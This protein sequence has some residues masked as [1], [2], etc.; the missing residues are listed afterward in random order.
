MVVAGGLWVKVCRKVPLFRL[1]FFAQL[2]GIGHSAL[3]AEQLLV[4]D[5][6]A[7]EIRWGGRKLTGQHRGT[8]KVLS[9]SV[10]LINGVPFSGSLDVDMQS[11][12]NTDILSDNWRAKLE[13]HLKSSDF[14]AVEDFPKARLTLVRCTSSRQISSQIQCD[15]RLHLKGRE[16]PVT[17][18][19]SKKKSEIL[20]SFT[21]DRTK[22]GVNYR[23]P[24]IAN[25]ILNQI[26][27]DEVQVDASIRFVEE[28]SQRSIAD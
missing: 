21:F 23:S 24:K 7:S 9:G 3:A 10:R 14:F 1:I 18:V 15:C 22:W 27:Y 19:V 25:R 5:A 8:L 28:K 2:L 16:N 20:G 17:V 12:Q 13:D 26:I 4:V 6:V 11:I